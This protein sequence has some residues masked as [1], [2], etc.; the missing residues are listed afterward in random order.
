MPRKK[1]VSE[2]PLYRLRY[3]TICA[4]L[5][6]YVLCIYMWYMCYI[7][8]VHVYVLCICDMYTLYTGIYIYTLYVHTSPAAYTRSAYYCF[9][10]LQYLDSLPLTNYR[11]SARTYG[12]IMMLGAAQLLRDVLNLVI[13]LPLRQ[14]I[15]YGSRTIWVVWLLSVS[16]LQNSNTKYRNCI[17]LSTLLSVLSCVLRSYWNKLAGIKSYLIHD[18]TIRKEDL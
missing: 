4:F 6:V 2:L 12:S 5:C 11:H 10:V 14:S 1:L 3:K 18:M 16:V 13:L 15:Q 8:G 9:L 7:Y 17:A